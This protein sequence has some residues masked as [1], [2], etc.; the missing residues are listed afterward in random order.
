MRTTIVVTALLTLFG[1]TVADAATSVALRPLTPLQ[2][3]GVQCGA[4]TISTT[5]TG[6]DGAYATTYTDATTRCGGSGRGG[7]YKTK[8]YHGCASARYTLTGQ[9]RDYVG[10]AC[11]APNPNA[12]FATDTGYGEATVSGRAVLILP[13]V[14]PTYSW[15]GVD[16]V[17]ATLGE[18]TEFTAA[19]MNPST[20]PLHVYS[21]SAA[22]TGVSATTDPADC[23]EIDLAPGESCPFVV[24][25]YAGNEEVGAATIGLTADTSSLTSVSFSQPVRVLEPPTPPPPPPPTEIGNVAFGAS[26][27]DASYV[28][29]FAPDDQSLVVGGQWSLADWSLTLDYADGSTD[30]AQVWTIDVFTQTDATTYFVSGA[31]VVLDAAG[32]IGKTIAWTLTISSP[33]GVSLS[34]AGGT[35]TL[36]TP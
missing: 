6:F 33:D 11:T 3:L 25:V 1:A 15:T 27:C 2:V 13:A 24:S 36:S 12:I 5:A 20:V 35:L 23:A 29:A 18:P 16:V 14:T 34:L 22:G 28:C 32:N 21:V 17:Q 7:G 31:N 19:I 30:V 10:T 9:L 26:A 4:G 8:T